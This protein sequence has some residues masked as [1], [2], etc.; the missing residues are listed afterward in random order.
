VLV[1]ISEGQF[2]W[3]LQGELVERVSQNT[4]NRRGNPFVEKTRL[5]P[6][7][8]QFP[9][10]GAPQ[11]GFRPLGRPFSWEWG[12]RVRFAGPSGLSPRGRVPPPPQVASV[13]AGQ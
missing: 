8:E 6:V 2:V 9:P 12:K 4:R 13:S 11:E 10:V 7:S 1:M 5:K 3:Y